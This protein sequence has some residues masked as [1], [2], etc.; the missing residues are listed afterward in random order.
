MPPLP[1]RD[2]RIPLSAAAAMT[3]RYRASGGP[4]AVR[5][6]L[7][8]SKVFEDLLA[9]KGCAGIRIYLGCHEDDSLGLVMVAVDADGRDIVA[10]ADGRYQEGY[11][12]QDGVECP[13]FCDEGSPLNG[14]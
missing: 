14:E 11:V 8:P 12:V 5:A 2:H 9:R 13:P 10:G 1:N 3:R 4:G 6:G 7:F